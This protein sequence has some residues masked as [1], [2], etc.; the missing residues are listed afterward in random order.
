MQ[1][2]ANLLSCII[3][4]LS[5]WV[6]QQPQNSWA[7]MSSLLASVFPVFCVI[8]LIFLSWIQS[9]GSK[10]SG[11]FLAMNVLTTCLLLWPVGQFFYRGNAFQNELVQVFPTKEYKIFE[12]SVL[13]LFTLQDWFNSDAPKYQVA[14]RHGDPLNIQVFPAQNLSAPCVFQIHGGG[15]SKGDYRQLA[16]YARFL[17]SLGYSVVSTSYRFIPEHPWPAQ[18]EDVVDVFQEIASSPQKYGLQA[19]DFILSGRSA[20]G[21]LALAAGLKLKDP[22]IRGIISFYPVVDFKLFFET[23]YPGDLLDS[24][25][26]LSQL[27]RSTPLSNPA[28]YA[29]V[30]PVNDISPYSP[31]VLLLHGDRDSVVPVRH[32]QIMAEHLRAARI[33][34]YLLELPYESHAFDLNL[35]GPGGQAA[36]F[37]VRQFLTSIFENKAH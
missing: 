37:A 4:I 10:R 35:N 30:N 28:I 2:V 12:P 24:P 19:K 18:L 21:H 20:G 25:T 23:G 22:R 1:I 7:W 17:N 27:L 16:N 36:S 8:F 26:L 14:N 13:K 34:H 11:F 9:H 15:Y 29:D 6:Y 32:S 5:V 3:L 31:P 33:P